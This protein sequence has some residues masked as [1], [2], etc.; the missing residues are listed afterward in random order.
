VWGDFT[1]L[2][3]GLVMAHNLSLDASAAKSVAA[4]VLPAASILQSKAVGPV[5]AVD[6]GLAHGATSQ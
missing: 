5:S 6:G 4:G 2:A 1:D 3:I